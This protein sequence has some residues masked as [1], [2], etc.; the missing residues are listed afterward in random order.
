MSPDR[1]AGNVMNPQSLD[2]YTYALNN[3]VANIDPLGLDPCPKGVSADVC[4]VATVDDIPTWTSPIPGLSDGPGTGTP[5]DNRIGGGPVPSYGQVLK[6]FN[7]C[8]ANF[9]DKHSIASLLHVNNSLV[10][11]TLFGSTTA[12][13]SNLFF[14]SDPNAYIPAGASLAAGA[15]AGTAFKVG[16]IAAGKLPTGGKIYTYTGKTVATPYGPALEMGRTGEKL[17]DTAVG[18]TALSGVKGVADM[19][20]FA[21]PAFIAYDE[22][23]YGV[24]EGV[25]TAQAFR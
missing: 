2:R 18:K 9:A 17:A 3:P 21:A 6:S 16:A 23:M 19:L 4:V 20:E 25:C 15:K 7:N 12:A 14:K 11:N 24:G 8:A 22:L 5:G 13:V 10:G 1:L